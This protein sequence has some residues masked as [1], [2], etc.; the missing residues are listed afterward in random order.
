VAE[1][2][3]DPEHWFVMAPCWSCQRFFRFHPELVPSLPIDPLTGKPLDIDPAPDGLAAA[4]ARAV[5]MPIC[6][7]CLDKS[8]AIRRREGREEIEVLSGAYPDE[9]DG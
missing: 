2:D 6:R 7:A 1:D 5:R 4:R 9:D 3:W 8:N